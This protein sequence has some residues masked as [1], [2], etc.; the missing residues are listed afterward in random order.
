MSVL[1]PGA[2]TEGSGGTVL[3]WVR[4]VRPGAASATEMTLDGH[5]QDFSTGGAVPGPHGR[6]PRGPGG[7]AGQAALASARSAGA[8]PAELRLTGSLRLGGTGRAAPRRR[9][10]AKGLG[11]DVQR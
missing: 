10:D 3:G 1:P 5:G 7:P 9:A 11:A 8:D 4:G 2:G 6:R